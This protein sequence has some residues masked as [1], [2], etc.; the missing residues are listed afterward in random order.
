M[1]EDKS[2]V[3]DSEEMME[4]KPW[5]IWRICLGPSTELCIREGI[6]AVGTGQLSSD[7]GQAIGTELCSSE[8][9]Q[10]LGL[11]LCRNDG[12]QSPGPVKVG[13]VVI[14]DKL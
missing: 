14:E 1:M 2:Y 7:G 9:G 11:G 10:V 5:R 13:A 8:G 12:G 6:L 3:Q 4:D